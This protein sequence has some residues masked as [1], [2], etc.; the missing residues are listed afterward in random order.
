MNCKI[1]T[2]KTDNPTG[3]CDGCKKALNKIK[4]LMEHQ[5]PSNNSE[6]LKYNN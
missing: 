1:C 2:K 5:K 6:K 3:V 4:I